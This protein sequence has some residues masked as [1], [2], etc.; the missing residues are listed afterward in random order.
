MK[1][2]VLDVLMYL[3]DHVFDAD[4]ESEADQ[5]TLTD[6]LEAAGFEKGEIDK[7]FDWLDDLRLAEDRTD[8]LKGQALGSMRVYADCELARFT[9]G[10]HGF[11]LFMEQSAIIDAQLREMII[12]RAMALE[13][14][15]IDLEHLKWVTM[16][17]LCNSSREDGPPVE[18]VE[19]L[20]LDEFTDIMH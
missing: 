7:A 13:T 2:N 8:C 19:E 9:D 16:M 14:P 18:W 6:E 20:M 11:M 10:C 4:M 17:V 15:E 5:D 1:E 3:F 12:E